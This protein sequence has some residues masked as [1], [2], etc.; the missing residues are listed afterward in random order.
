M[1]KTRK[2]AFAEELGRDRR[3]S[4]GFSR[5]VGN[6][7]K[8]SSACEGVVWLVSYSQRILEGRGEGVTLSNGIIHFFNF[9]FLGPL[10]VLFL[11]FF[12]FLLGYKV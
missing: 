9:L 4:G 3:R 2:K 10:S 7:K 8:T 5:A 12:F 6:E 11:S 1:A